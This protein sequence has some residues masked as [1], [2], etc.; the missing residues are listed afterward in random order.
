MKEADK[1]KLSY[2]AT[3]LVVL[4]LLSLSGSPSFFIYTDSGPGP[5]AAASVPQG[6][7]GAGSGLPPHQGRPTETRA[8]RCGV[9]DSSPSAGQETFHRGQDAETE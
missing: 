3:P 7:R 4:L 2:R 6:R 9:R 5:R 1:P 8:V